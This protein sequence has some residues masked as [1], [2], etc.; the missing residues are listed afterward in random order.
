M[1]WDFGTFCWPGSGLDWGD[2][3]CGSCWGVSCGRFVGLTPFFLWGHGVSPPI[4]SFP[5]SFSFCF[6]GLRGSEPW[7]CLWTWLSFYFF[8][9]SSFVNIG[10]FS[11]H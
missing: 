1:A 4:F 11:E 10:T 7:G 8:F 5:F 6:W 9:F 2:M 3:D